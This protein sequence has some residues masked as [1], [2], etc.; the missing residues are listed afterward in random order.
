M[1]ICAFDELMSVAIWVPNMEIIE[2][3]EVSEQF[4]NVQ[5]EF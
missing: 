2:G 5:F 1:L 4:T 3:S